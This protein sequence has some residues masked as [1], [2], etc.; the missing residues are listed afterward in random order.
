MRAAPGWQPVNSVEI[1]F[2]GRGDAT[3]ETFGDCE[4]SSEEWA[5]DSWNG[6]FRP[7]HRRPGHRVSRS[8]STPR[9]HASQGVSPP[10]GPFAKGFPHAF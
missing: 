7:L 10:A 9:G 2:A 6:P 5:C 1:R 8:R 4:G 3:Y